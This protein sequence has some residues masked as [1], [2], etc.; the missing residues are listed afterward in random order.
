MHLQHMGAQ[1]GVSP[2]VQGLW[3]DY[4][5]IQRRSNMYRDNIYEGECSRAA[6]LL[7]LHLE[8]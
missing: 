4:G 5:E 8:I 3:N 2:P 6:T 1:G 7:R